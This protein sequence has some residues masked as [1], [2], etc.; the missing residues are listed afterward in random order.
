VRSALL[1]AVLAAGV[2]SVGSADAAS[3]KPPR[4]L[5]AQ[6][7]AVLHRVFGN[8]EPRRVSYIPYPRKIAVVLEFDRL[9]VCGICSSPTSGSQPRGRVV[10]ISFDRRTHALGGAP[11]GW[12]M[13]FCEVTK[14]KPPKAACL[15]R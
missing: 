5:L 7:A 15:H 4:W 12:A 3:F 11:D 1:I 8:A 10:R 13:R 14:N 2:M 9:V 6:E